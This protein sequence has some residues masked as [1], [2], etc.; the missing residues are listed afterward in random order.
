MAPFYVME[1]VK[2]ASRRA[3]TH[4]DVIE[5]CV[6]QP[7]TPAPGPVLDAARDALV[8]GP[9][10]YTEA[11]GT[12]PVREAIARHYREWYGLD[13]PASR[14]A[15]TT[16]SSAAFTAVFLAAFDAGD[17]VAVTR[18]GYAAYRNTLDALG[19]RVLDLDCGEQDRFQP[20]VAG[21]ERL[22]RRT[23][24]P[25]RGLVLASPSNPTGTVI[26]PAE[27]AAI[28]RWCEETGCLLISDEIYHGI[29]FGSVRDET[30]AA[31]SSEPVVIGSFSK[32]FSMT[33]WR[34]GWAVL[35]DRL[36][37][38]VELLLGN[39]NLCPPALSQ[40]AAVVAFGVEA[41]RELRGHVRRYAANR[42]LLMDRL[43]GLGVTDF[44]PP[45]G[46]FYA[47]LDVSHLC[48]DSLDWS[49][50]LLDATGVAV[51]PGIDFARDVPAGRPDA[52]PA[53]NG[54]RFVRVSLCGATDALDEA[55]ARMS[56]F[57]SA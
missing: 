45:D 41:E 51:A 53:L 23:G 56:G 52:D 19:V 9:L 2:A 27:L 29:T 21:L 13:I 57:A 10:G 32:F 15:V 28:V 46:A 34:L 22:T 54:S 17:E 44:V 12:A 6:G 16:G 47:W 35:P 36:V 39:L 24:R 25:P 26:D 8:A 14:I 20:T 4:G 5:L 43:P 3:A 18:P 55:L 11:L 49:L 30:A 50:R 42:A 1:L 37:R 31:T 7:S 33:G 48:E 38:P 40:A